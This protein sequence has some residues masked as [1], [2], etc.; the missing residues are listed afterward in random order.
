MNTRCGWGGVARTS[1]DPPALL[2]ESE[3]ARAGGW[4][5]APPLRLVRRTTA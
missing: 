5:P 2:H 4:N 3:L 1:R